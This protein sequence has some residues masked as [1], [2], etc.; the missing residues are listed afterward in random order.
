DNSDAGF[1]GAGTYFVEVTKI[2]ANAGEG[3]IGCTSAPIQFEIIDLSVNPVFT[4]DVTANTACDINNPD[5]TFFI[6]PDRNGP[7]PLAPAF[8]SWS[9]DFTADPYGIDPKPA[10]LS[11]TNN[12]AL[13]ADVFTLSSV[14]AG[15]YDYTITDDATGCTFNG[16]LV[17]PDNPVAPVLDNVGFAI[18][19]QFI[20]NPEGSITISQ[21]ETVVS[22]LPGPPAIDP[23][24]SLDVTMANYSFV[25]YINAV[26]PAN[27]I[28]D[29]N[30][31]LDNTDAGFLGAGTYFVEVTKIAANAGEG[32]I[33]CTSAPI[34]FEILD[35]SVNPVFTYDVTANTVCDILNPDGSF[36]I[37]PDRNG[38]DLLAPAFTSWTID[39]TADP[40]GTLGAGNILA[41]EGDV[42]T[43]SGLPDGQYDFTITD[44]ATGCAFNGS[45]SIATNP[46]A[47]VLDNVGFTIVDQLVCNPDGSIEITQIE[48]VISGLPGPPATQPTSV[49]DNNMTNYEFTWYRDAVDPANIVFGPQVGGIDPLTDGNFLNVITYIPL[50][51]TDVMGAG[52][53]FVTYQKIGANPGEGGIGCDSAPVSFRIDDL[54]EDPL[55]TF[56]QTSNT[57]CDLTVANGEITAFA[58][59]GG[60]PVPAGSVFTWYVGTDTSAP[61]FLDGVD[62]TLDQSVAGQET[63]RDVSPGPYTVTV[64][65]LT[66]GCSFTSSFEVEDQPSIPNIILDGATVLDQD[67][68]NPSGAIIISDSD[69]SLG[70]NPVSVGE[71]IFTWTLDNPTNTPLDSAGTGL[72]IQGPVLDT[73]VYNA[74]GAGDYFISITPKAGEGAGCPGPPIKV[75][76]NDISTDPIISFTT[77]S[78]SS[79]DIANPN[80]AIIAT[81][82]EMDGSTTDPYTFEWEYNGS[83]TLPAGAVQIDTLNLSTISGAL[84]GSYRIKA[85]NNATGCITFSGIEIVLDRTVSEPNIIEVSKTDPVD[86]NPTGRLEVISVQINGQPANVV[87]FEFEWYLDNVDPANLILNSSGIPITTANLENQLPGQ[88]FV[89]ARDLNTRCE[90]IAKE[91]NILSDNI[92]FPDVEINLDR[93]QTSCDVTNPNGQ[94]SATV[95]GGNDDTNPDYVF[96]WYSGFD[97]SGSVAGTGSTLTNAKAGGYT[98]EVQNIITGCSSTA[99]FV[100][101][102]KTEELRLQ[103]SVSSLAVDFCNVDNGVIEARVTN[104]T[105]GNFRY[106]WTGPNGFTATGDRIENVEPG[107]YNVIA[108][109]IDAI[110][111]TS[112]V[113]T[114]AVEDNRQLPVLEVIMDNPMTYCDPE[115]PNGQLT[116]TVNGEVVGFDFNWYNGSSAAG[117][118]METTN[119]YSG[120]TAGDYTVVVTDQRTQCENQETREIE[121]ATITPPNPNATVLSNLTDCVTPNGEIEADVNGNQQD[122]IFDW[123]DGS[124]VGSSVDNTGEIY[125]ELDLGDYTVTAT[126]IITGCISEGVIREITDE[127]EIP[128]FT[129]KTKPAN[130]ETSNG[131]IELVFE[132]PVDLKDVLWFDQQGNEIDRSTNLY[133]Y[134]AG[135]YDVIVTTF[136]GCENMGSAEIRTEITNYNG[137][138]ANNDGSNDVFQIDC[139]TMFPNN[140][141][142]IFNRAG[143]L[144]YEEDGYD[145][146]ENVFLGIGLNGL[147]LAGEEL[148]DGT[149]FY[150]ID[151]GD[152]SRPVTGYLELIR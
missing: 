116:A 119:I 113:E 55:I 105:V 66:S 108:T 123:Y 126:D 61:L 3:G 21:I 129:F 36:F 14:R 25:W 42:F 60:V 59:T 89:I 27:I 6:D 33:G 32:G 80:G 151:K 102:D 23:T 120:L 136:L 79:C 150:I 86:C 99:I 132:E 146:E 83:T 74:M 29:N 82:Q 140:N 101:E 53:Y 130:C 41:A 96:L 115:R 149:Y 20:C 122:Y 51:A 48:T 7:D 106:D 124:S 2:A 152:G 30:N 39:F 22:G 62:G 78:N 104:H 139:I 56:T 100:I 18:V 127:R 28:G 11:A 17:V 10:E 4:Y 31:V 63:L 52:T 64:T 43:A 40:S 72:P 1:L 19:D 15:Q 67:I 103:L 88:Y 54:S 118:I 5:G 47:P 70:G 133:D 112:F 69:I 145:N 68:C 137:I 77:I 131:F 94:L 45:L 95:D 134:P 26:A 143:V 84:D 75:V 97:T 148:P 147:Y 114:I 138:S 107:T 117:Q 38:P 71:F 9:I 13:E 121:D 98:V 141:V 87:D 34:Q 12:L 92:I 44:N 85:T 125:R 57:T 111:C 142:K 144:V 90:S 16:S 35:L 135:F 73:T 37:D 46:V 49:S 109:D 81:I 76:V 50:G 93:P 8:T 110:F 128:E 58:A 91:V 65:H 24:S